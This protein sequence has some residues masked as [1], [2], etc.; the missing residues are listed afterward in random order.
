MT[1]TAGIGSLAGLAGSL[2]LRPGAAHDSLVSRRPH[3]L[4]RALRG[5]PA[6]ALPGLLASLFSACGAVHRLGAELALCSAAS[7]SAVQP[8]AAQRHLLQWHTLRAH[9]QAIALDWPRLLAGGEPGATQAGLVLLTGCPLRVAGSTPDAAAL[10]AL[11]SWLQTQVFHQPLPAWLA[12]WQ[13]DPAAALCTWADRHAGASAV[14]SWLQRCRGVASQPLPTVPS[15]RAPAD[16]AGLRT[17]VGEARAASPGPTWQGRCA[18]TGPTTR[19][20]QPPQTLPTAWLRLGARLADLARLALPDGEAVARGCH[21]LALGALPLAPGA[22]VAWVES[23]RGLLLQAL[24]LAPG[25]A[26]AKLQDAL[27]LSPTDWHSHPAGGFA[28]ALAA[29]PGDAPEA[30]VQAL[31]AAYDPCVPCVIESATSIA[32]REEAHHA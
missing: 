24:W 26:G 10:A 13:A 2:R 6:T 32:S 7:G 27:V 25:E 21:G 3:G 18:E 22:A 28:Q 14:A 12:A 29:L 1:S 16:A 8:D 20:A 30:A 15:L 11:P 4:V 23:S 5:Q 31:V 9:L 17:L 19:L